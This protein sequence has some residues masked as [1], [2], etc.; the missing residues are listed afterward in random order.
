MAGL[1][2]VPVICTVESTKGVAD[3]VMSEANIKGSASLQFRSDLTLL[4]SSD[5]ESSNKSQMYFYD[6]KG[7]AQPIV[8]VR[9]SKSKMSSF[10]KSIYFKFHR[11]CSKFVEC[12]P[13][14]Q[15]E[16]SRKD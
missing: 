2:S 10:R 14:E 9:V 13:M 5:F 3:T 1:Y 12:M 15:Q 16:Y 8:Q 4:L 11:D 6:E 7:V